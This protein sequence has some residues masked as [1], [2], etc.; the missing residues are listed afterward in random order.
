MGWRVIVSTLSTGRVQRR[1]FESLETARIYA[2]RF[3]PYG[4][5]DFGYRVE[6]YRTQRRGVNSH[7]HTEHRRG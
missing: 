4:R 1:G 5:S 3:G 2:A 7:D 6:L